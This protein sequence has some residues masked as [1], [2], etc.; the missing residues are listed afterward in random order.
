MTTSH[1]KSFRVLCLGQVGYKHNHYLKAKAF[2]TVL[3]HFVFFLFRS[4]RNVYE[5]LSFKEP[6]QCQEI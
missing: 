2:R 3:V 5:A 1:T 6:L 4:L